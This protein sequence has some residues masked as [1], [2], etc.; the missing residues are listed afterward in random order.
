MPKLIEIYNDKLAEKYDQATW[1]GKWKAPNE[2]IKILREVKL[3]KKGLKILDLGIGTGQEIEPFINKN[4]EI[5]GVDISRKMLKIC[6]A[7]HPELK[8]IKYDISKGLNRLNFKNKY[9]DLIIAIGILEFVKNIKKIIKEVSKLLNDGAH[10]IF[11]YELLMPN[12]KFQKRKLQ[13]NA[14]DYIKNPPSS[15]KFKL[16]RKSRNE[17]NRM[18]KENKYKIIRH[19]KIRAFLKGPAKIPVYYSLVLAK[20][21]KRKY[22]DKLYT[23]QPLD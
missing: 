3:I 7:K 6:K 1:K 19:F 14:E 15:M 2:A 20:K 16:Y 22:Y 17:I 5:Y 8:I 21:M 4:C 9:F 11:T 23:S 13:Y 10:F 12:Y 18:L